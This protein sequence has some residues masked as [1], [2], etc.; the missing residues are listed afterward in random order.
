MVEDVEQL[1]IEAEGYMLSELLEQAQDEMKNST[2]S[3]Q[4]RIIKPLESAI[5]NAKSFTQEV[6]YNLPQQK[7]AA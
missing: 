1:G 7:A 2:A 3:Q 4:E 6:V 5:Q